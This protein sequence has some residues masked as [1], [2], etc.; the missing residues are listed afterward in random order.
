MEPNIAFAPLRASP[1]DTTSYCRYGANKAMDARLASRL[2]STVVTGA[3]DTAAFE[4]SDQERP[5]SSD[6]RR[7]VAVPTLVH[8][9]PLACYCR[10]CRLLLSPISAAKPAAAAPTQTWGRN[11]LRR[12]TARV[13]HASATPDQ[14]L[15]DRPEQVS[16]TVFDSATNSYEQRQEGE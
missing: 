3:F 2:P 9:L 15:L 14:A 7:L 12:C 6:K 11:R 5:R 4:A 8:F 16:V 13:R 1:L 10:S